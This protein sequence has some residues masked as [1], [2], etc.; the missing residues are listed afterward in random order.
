MRELKVNIEINGIQT[1]VGVIKEPDRLDL[2][3]NH[4][5]ENAEITRMKTVK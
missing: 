3:R 5:D 1:P 2:G 4:P